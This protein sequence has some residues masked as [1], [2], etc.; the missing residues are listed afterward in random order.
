MAKKAKP[1]TPEIVVNITPQPLEGVAYI[2]QKDMTEEERRAF[3]L[4]WEHMNQ[5]TGQR[6]FVLMLPEHVELKEL[7]TPHLLN[8][9]KQITAVLQERG[10]FDLERP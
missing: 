4:A 3:R 10:A 5:K 7:A 1:K 6:R 8:L 9:Q 2:I